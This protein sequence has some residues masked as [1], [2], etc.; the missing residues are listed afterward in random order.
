MSSCTV[1]QAL[2]TKNLT[3]TA[4]AI[5]P[6]VD[7]SYMAPTIAFVVLSA[8]AVSLRVISRV[9]AKPAVWWDDFI[10]TLSFLGEIAFSA[11]LWACT[12]IWA[13]PFHDITLNRRALYLLFI[14]YVTSR[15]LVRLSILLF[16]HRRFGRDPLARRL[17]RWTFGAI[18][19]CC[20][21]FDLAIMFGCTPISYFWTSWDGEHE[22]HCISTSGILWGGAFV[23]IAID[24]WVILIPLP[25][26]M[27]LKFSLRQKMLA[28]GMFAFGL[29]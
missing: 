14:L 9:Q 7:H 27:K 10:I 23:A 19:A 20:I 13:V 4:C 11:I 12:D 17:I 8:V 5:S 3:N 18:V 22:G 26:I 28:G 29:L 15:Y 16:F 2:F 21:A 24:V 1:R 25:F 6:H